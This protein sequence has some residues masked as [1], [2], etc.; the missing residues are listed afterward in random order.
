MDI[1]GITEIAHMEMQLADFYLEGK[2]R[3]EMSMRV[4]DMNFMTQ[5]CLD[6]G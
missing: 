2:V 3:P 6:L 1:F 4:G 5:T